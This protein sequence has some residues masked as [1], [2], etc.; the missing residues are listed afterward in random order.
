MTDLSKQAD[1][2]GYPAVVPKH[3]NVRYLHNPIMTVI[4]SNIRG[5][6]K[7]AT[8]TFP[9]FPDVLKHPSLGR[10]LKYSINFVDIWNLLS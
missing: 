4:S 6:P 9:F 10:L 7:Q 1:T 2:L 8:S 3:K 5:D